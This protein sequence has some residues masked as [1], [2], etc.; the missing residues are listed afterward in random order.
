LASG[1]SSHVEGWFAT[2]SGRYSHAEGHQVIASGTA[3]HAEGYQANAS[4]TYSHAEGHQTFAI[5][6]AT[7]AEGSLT[8]A[9]GSYSHAEGRLTI[10]SGSYSHAEGLYSVTLGDYAHAEGENT[11]ANGRSSHAEGTYTFASGSHS[12]A[13][14]Y[15]TEAKGQRS[16]AEGFYTIAIGDN[17][18]AQGAYTTASGQYSLAAGY[19]TNATANGQ[20]VVGRYN[21]T[22]SDAVF[23]VGVGVNNISLRNGL[24]V[25]QYSTTITSPLTASII[26]GS[27]QGTASFAA[28]SSVAFSSS[29]ALTA[30]NINALEQQV[31]ITGSVDMIG[32]LTVNGTASFTYVT[33]SQTLVD[34]NTITVFGSGSVLSTAGYLAVDTASVYDSG[35]WL[36]DFV[37]QS[38]VTTT[39][40]TAPTMSG[41]ASFAATYPTRE[42]TI[43]PATASWVCDHNLGTQW[44]QVTCWDTSTNMVIQPDEIESLSTASVKITWTTPVEGVARIS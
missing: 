21:A 8:S 7:H 18:H 19:F 31:T 16:H 20:T 14:G 35:S 41:T 17:S 24:E 22:S 38:W 39:A 12:H 37:D 42:F 2:A 32:N 30:S 15:Y 10:T 6:Y 26:S 29:Y 3:S 33:A 34:Q 13:E 25:T 4:G 5:G 11:T 27:L 23:V 40:I 1:F 28:T 36:Y 43:T 9:T 44:V